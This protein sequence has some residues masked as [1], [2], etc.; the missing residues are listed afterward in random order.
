MKNIFILL[1]SLL[2]LGSCDPEDSTSRENTKEII[3]ELLIKSSEE[4][5][6]DGQKLFLRAALWRDFMPISPPSGKGLIA[7]N[8]LVHRD[9]AKIPSYI[10]LSKQYVINGDSLWM[11]EYADET[12]ETPDYLIERVSRNGPKWGPDIT[13]TVIAEVKSLKDDNTYYLRLDEESIWRT[14]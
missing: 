11:S 3:D 8:Y 9:S 2:I 10:K 7:V 4:I 6:I 12:R 13:V 5:N 14:D 1:I